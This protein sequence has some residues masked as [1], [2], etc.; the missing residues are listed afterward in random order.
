M[1]G[2][3]RTNPSRVGRAVWW[4]SELTVEVGCGTPAVSK[5]A[6]QRAASDEPGQRISLVRLPTTVVPYPM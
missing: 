2:L 3:N 5:I 6:L 4:E 1:P